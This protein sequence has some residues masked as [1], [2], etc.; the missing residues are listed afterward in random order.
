MSR[1]HSKLA[2]VLVIAGLAQAGQ[3][4]MMDVRMGGRKD[5]PKKDGKDYAELI[6]DADVVAGLFT[7]YHDRDKET[8]WME[9]LPAQLDHDFILSMTQ[10]TG[11]GARGVLSGM[12]AGHDIIRFHKV[13]ESIQVIQRNL[14]FRAAEGSATAPMI[15]RNFSDS[16]LAALKIECLPHEERG[17]WLVDA[18]ALFLKDLSGLGHRLERRLD[19]RYQMDDELCWLDHLQSFP[20]NTE[21]GASLAFSTDKPKQG[22]STLNDPRS[23]QIRMRYSLSEVP[24]SSYRPRLADPRVGYFQTGWRQF[25]DDR[26]GDPMIRLANRWNLEKKDPDAAISEPVEPIVYWL[27]NAIPEAYRDVIRDGALSWNK[28]FEQ[29]GF[30]NALVV[31]Q[32]PDSAEW[33]PADIRY[34]TI[35]WISS[36]EPSFGAMG[37]SQVNPYTGEILNADILIEADM[38]RRAGWGWRSGVDPRGGMLPDPSLPPMEEGLLPEASGTQQRLPGSLSHA[39]C[40]HALLGAQASDWVSLSLLSEGAME[41]GGEIP[42]E[43]VSQ[44]L[45]SMTAHEVGHTLGLRHNFRGSRLLPFDALHDK[46][47]TADGLVNSV[48]EYDPPN[49]ALSSAGQG[50]YFTSTLGPYDLWAIRW[51]YTPTGA[52]DLESDRAGMEAIASESTDPSLIYGTD[53]DAYDVYGW[54]SAVDPQCRIFDLSSNELAWTRHQLALAG[55]LMA[56][57][58]AR[59][60][61]PDDDY[62][63]YRSAF[64]RSFGLYWNSAQG[65]VRYAG[66]MRTRREP[67]SKGLAPLDPY[68]GQE[69]REALQLLVSALLDPSPWQIPARRLNQLG[70]GYRWSFD[71]STEVERVDMPLHDLLAI[72]RERIL[73]DLFAPRR[74]DRVSELSA[75]PGAEDALGLDELFAMFSDP[76]WAETARDLDGRALQNAHASVMIDLLTNEKLAAGRDARLL[77]RAELERIARSVG[78]WQAQRGSDRL[79]QAHLS[80]LAARVDAALKLERDRL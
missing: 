62:L 26:P 8:V 16:P 9:I 59:L 45:Y 32:M 5:A 47:A 20:A 74:L 11:I 57:D 24:E 61:A 21:I 39:S 72:N 28:A 54:G 75:R 7:L 23:L 19:S 14:M 44:Y 15:E 66:A 30:R 71:G 78:Q 50:D 51:G 34:N 2:L 76:I 36:S 67:A 65:L 69:Q 29:A 58:P 38:V 42:W 35:R 22:W 53:E 18:S 25:G 55:K 33:D 3:D 46:A 1:V 52:T 80:D 13:G 4:G 10:E 41:P 63:V 64:Q 60:L 48:M 73:Q 56:A 79:T 6:K 37:P 77:A 40:Q 43:Y 27:E 31:K 68:T 17:S 70:Q 12:P 49:V